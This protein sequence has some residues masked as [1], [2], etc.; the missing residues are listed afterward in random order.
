M[1]TLADVLPENSKTIDAIYEHYK[2][3]GDAEPPREYLGMSEI[4]DECARKLWYT[5][6]HCAK[7]DFPGR[8]YR[9]FETG[10]LEEI[11]LVKDLRDIG[12]DVNSV[13]EH[14]E[15]FGFSLLGGHFSGHMDGC[16]LGIPEAPKTWHVLEFKTHNNK[17]F[18]KLK[19]SGV[20]FAKPKHYCQMQCYMGCSGMKRALYLAVN[21]DTDEIYSERVEFDKEV[22]DLAVASAREIIFNTTPPA[23]IASRPDDWRCTY[24]CARRLCF[25]TPGTP[26]LPIVQISCRQCCYAEATEVGIGQWVCKKD[27]RSLTFGDQRN[28]CFNYL[29]IPHLFS[30]FVPVDFCDDTITIQDPKGTTVMYGKN[31]FDAASLMNLPLSA[32]VNSMVREAKKQE[33]DSTFTKCF[34]DDL[35]N[36]YVNADN[37]WEG[38][39]EDFQKEWI[40]KLGEPIN[41]VR[42]FDY[43][44]AEFRHGYAFIVKDNAKTGTF[45]SDIPF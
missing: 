27:S 35:Y 7:E 16:A 42:G 12:C 20:R 1:T 33:P 2:K 9:L 8:L 45:Y 5:F 29:P 26:L 19:K 25:P 24:C 31:G 3:T 30:G 38:T 22:F 41:M 36:K 18:E 39:M 23:P 6:H 21:K 17:S 28:A 13:N 34:T 11:R 44:L 43:R 32:A 37:V 40:P 10:D 14:G 4:G 15:Q